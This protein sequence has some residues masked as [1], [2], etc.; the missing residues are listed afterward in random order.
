MNSRLKDSIIS[1]LSFIIIFTFFPIIVAAPCEY[2]REGLY[3]GTSW[4]TANPEDKC[5]D[6]TKLAQ[7]TALAQKHG[8]DLIVIRDGKIVAQAGNITSNREGA[9]STKTGTAALAALL[10][11]QKGT[12]QAN[13]KVSAINNEFGS[14]DVTYADLMTMSGG[15]SHALNKP[16]GKGFTRA[17]DWAYSNC[18]VEYLGGALHIAAGEPLN[19]Y[20]MQE[21]Y[22]KIGASPSWTGGHPWG[23]SING[24][25]RVYTSMYQKW[26][27]SD[28][29]RLGLL[30]LRNG[31]W[32]GTSILDSALIVEFTKAQRP[33]LRH[34]FPDYYRH[35]GKDCPTFMGYLFWLNT[36]PVIT[37]A[38]EDLAC[39]MGSVGTGQ[40]FFYCFSKSTDIVFAYAGYDLRAYITRKSHY[41][42]DGGLI[43]H[44]FEAITGSTPPVSVQES[45]GLINHNSRFRI[46]SE[47]P[48]KGPVKF[49]YQSK[50]ENHREPIKASI[51]NINGRLVKKIKPRAH[52]GSLW[53]FQWDGLDST[54]QSVK[55]GLYFIQA[56][57]VL[58][59]SVK[60]ILIMD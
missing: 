8:S 60:R 42:N 39:G 25:S 18:G 3:P 57:G 37:Y 31:K 40:E 44:I 51:F 17:V 28:A 36:G 50:K 46:I 49:L 33:N 48:T 47:N 14:Q 13:N 59:N 55:P 15:Y 45:K 32:N 58:E 54:C 27:V 43:R 29:A 5:M 20:L 38:P 52:S 22:N 19:T 4:Q 34:A 10:L 11:I 2:A 7:A 23:S 24:I 1:L 21:V 35:N 30:L 53:L 12:I 16:C 9:S 6:A 56:A 26:S 41:Y